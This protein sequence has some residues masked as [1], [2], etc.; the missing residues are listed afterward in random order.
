MSRSIS[1]LIAGLVAFC[2]AA[3]SANN[4]PGFR[5]PAASGTVDGPAAPVTWNVPKGTNVKWKIPVPGLAHSSPIVW[6]RQVCL[7]S[8]IS[9]EGS[10]DL[11]VG[12]Y[13]NID[14]AADQ[15]PHRWVVLCYDKDTGKPLWEAT[16]HPGVPK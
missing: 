11:K 7:G 12:L 2:G 6:E 16:A 1:A 14:P 5:G 3:L 9:S 8:A 4:W 15:A 10:A 13:G